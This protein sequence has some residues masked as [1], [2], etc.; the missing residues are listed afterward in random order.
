MTEGTFGSLVSADGF[1]PDTFYTG[2]FSSSAKREVIQK[3]E[4]RRRKNSIRDVCLVK[5]LQRR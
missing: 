5:N 4:R 1:A 2:N 3:I